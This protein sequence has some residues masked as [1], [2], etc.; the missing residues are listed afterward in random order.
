MIARRR[1]RSDSGM[2]LLSAVMTTM[3]LA[4][5]GAALILM[6]TVETMTAANFVRRSEAASTDGNTRKRS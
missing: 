2:A 6:T 4:A 5:I 1:T 3:V